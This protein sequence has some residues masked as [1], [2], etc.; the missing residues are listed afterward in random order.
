MKKQ[1]S[2]RYEYRIF[3]EKGLIVE[4]YFGGISASF[5]K[6]SL[7]RL[8]EDSL[9]DHGYHIVVDFRRSV[10]EITTDDLKGLVD[11]HEETYRPGHGRTAIL[12]D[13]ARDTAFAIL[14]K[15]RVKSRALSIHSTVEGASSWLGMDVIPN[16]E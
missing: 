6:E 3:P 11:H 12:V 13:Q 14:V 1:I 2:G 8:R 16:V 5:I 7:Q 4:K 15:G 9:F 10:M